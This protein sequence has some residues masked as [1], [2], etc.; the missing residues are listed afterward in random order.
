MGRRRDKALA[1]TRYLTGTTGIPFIRWDGV[2]I[3]S[4]SP[5]L[6][7]LTT[8]SVWDRFGSKVRATNE[9][10][11]IPFV[12]RYDGYV[13]GVENAIVGTNLKAFT[14]LLHNY[15]QMGDTHGTTNHS[16]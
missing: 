3:E 11:G 9:Q 1:V 4:P 16:R 2:R 5:Y 7:E 14:Q 13:D 10:L 6:I 12:I 8:D 15:H